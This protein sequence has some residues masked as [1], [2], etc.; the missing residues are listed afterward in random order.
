MRNPRMPYALHQG[1]V[2]GRWR[3]IAQNVGFTLGPVI[4]ATIEVLARLSS[5]LARDARAIST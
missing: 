1:T 4:G 3:Q 2:A 5:A